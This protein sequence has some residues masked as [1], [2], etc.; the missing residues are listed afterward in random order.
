VNA[1]EPAFYPVRRRES[2]YIKDGWR[3]SIEVVD[4]KTEQGMTDVY[5]HLESDAER[6]YDMASGGLLDLLPQLVLPDGV[7][8]QG[9]GAGWGEGYASHSTTL[10]TGLSALQ[11]LEHLSGQLEVAGWQV[12]ERLQGELSGLV[13]F[14]R[15]G[16]GKVYDARLL[17]VTTPQTYRHQVGLEAYRRGGGDEQGGSVMFLSNPE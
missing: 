6:D 8:M 15:E 10:V 16:K 2:A 1:D 7:Q 11:L 9:H 3:L 4:E 5:L 17:I 13:T 12:T 14:E